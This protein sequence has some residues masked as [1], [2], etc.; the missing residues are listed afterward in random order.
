M[1]TAP[2]AKK[3]TGL[4]TVQSLFKHP[5][6]EEHIIPEPYYT[7]GKTE[8]VMPD[9]YVGL[10]LEIEF[11][12]GEQG[13]LREAGPQFRIDNDGSLR[14]N[15]REIITLPLKTKFVE[16]LLERFYH[17]NNIGEGNYSDRTST[18]VHMNVQD[19]TW[20]Q[21]R[22]MALVYQVVER[23]LFNFV[24]HERVDNIFCVPW[25]QSGI[26][27]SILNKIK[28]SP[29]IVKQWMKY[30]ALNLIPV[31]DQGTLEF[32]HLHGTCDVPLILNWINLLAS[33]RRYAGERSF[34]DVKE[35]I[36][37]M[38]T[39]SNYDLFMQD[40]FRDKVGLILKED[41]KPLLSVG[42]LDSKL[43]LME[44]QKKDNPYDMMWANDIIRQ[45]DAG[46][47]NRADFFIAD[48]I[49]EERPPAPRRNIVTDP[50]TIDAMRG[51]A[52]A[53]SRVFFDPV[54]GLV[55]QVW[56]FRMHIRNQ[57]LPPGGVDQL[58][59]LPLRQREGAV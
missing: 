52:R 40:V 39:V 11:P 12:A 43:L 7:T 56:D 50:R 2:K 13:R 14:N 32:R 44:Q 3:E 38:N 8:M 28:E 25:F 21:L 4:S 58:R 31:S 15:G 46:A 37:A 30:S 22:T 29:G 54:N 9:L 1:A 49:Q 17:V 33:I 36:L 57:D 16:T 35:N 34:E 51:A 48:D 5:K 6:V 59:P 20:D 47:G 41:Y 55:R 26:S 27:V 19:L 10:E 53:G 24:G 42:V 45:A 18:H 23:L